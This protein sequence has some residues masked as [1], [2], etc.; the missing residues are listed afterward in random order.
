MWT[1]R[2]TPSVMNDDS[3]DC[4]SFRDCLS[5]VAL[6]HRAFV[7]LERQS[8]EERGRSDA[9]KLKRIQLYEKRR[10]SHTRLTHIFSH[11]VC[12]ICA[13]KMGSAAVLFAESCINIYNCL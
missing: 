3:E 8:L 12:D 9:F 2:R 7:P 4:I 1:F 13:Y 10:P 11:K 5:R 6:S